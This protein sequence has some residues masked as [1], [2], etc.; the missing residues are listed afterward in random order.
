MLEESKIAKQEDTKAIDISV[1]VTPPIFKITFAECIH[2]KFKL[3]LEPQPL[4]SEST[5]IST[6]DSDFVDATETSIERKQSTESLSDELDDE[7]E[8]NGCLLW[9]KNWRQFTSVLP[10]ILLLFTIGLHNVFTV[11]ELDYFTTD[12]HGQLGGTFDDRLAFDPMEIHESNLI[13]KRK[14]TIVIMMWHLGAIIGSLFG[15]SLVRNMKKRSIYV[16]DRDVYV[17]FTVFI[18][19][20]FSYFQYLAALLQII[21]GLCFFTVENY[22]NGYNLRRFLGPIM[23]FFLVISARF[24]S[25]IV[26]GIVH[27][28]VTV[29]ASDIGS[30][31]MRQVISYW[32]IAIIAM[33]TAFYS[34]MMNFWYKNDPIF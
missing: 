9:G 14:S 19:F 16:S 10:G 26:C 12:S 21:A 17:S 20:S 27:L 1:S 7:Y 22:Y 33:S 30:K 18:V 24:L 4:A 31:R 28:T 5:E 13:Q 25:G 3:H 29:H 32:I 34:F 8:L 15:A 23:P 6:T 11:Y 2:E